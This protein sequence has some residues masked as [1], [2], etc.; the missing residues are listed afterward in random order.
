MSMK[1]GNVSVP[2]DWLDYNTVDADGDGNRT[3]GRHSG[4][5]T[6]HLALA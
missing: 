4:R 3:F 2:R 1:I 5:G 6:K